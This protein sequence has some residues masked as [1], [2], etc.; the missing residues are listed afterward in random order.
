M[1]IAALLGSLQSNA[2]DAKQAQKLLDEKRYVQAREIY[3]SL[4]QKT[5]EDA[6]INLRV[7]ICYLHGTQKSKAQAYLQKAFDLSKKPD[8]HLMFDLAEAMHYNNKFDEAMVMYK[9]SDHMGTNRFTVSKRISECAFG[10][11]Y[12]ASPVMAKL[13]NMGAMV[14]TAYN[15][16]LPSVTAD[17]QAMY[18]TTRR[19]GTTGGKMADDGQFYEDI[20]ICR[21]NGGTWAGPKQLAA[22]INTKDNDACTAISSNGQT[23]FIYRGSDGGDI[24]ISELHGDVWGKPEPF[25]YNTKALETSAF[26]SFDEKKLY[27]VSDRSG[28][29]D[30]YYCLKNPN[31]S[32]GHPIRCS[33]SVNTPS[34][35][36]SPF[37][38]SDGRALYFS[39]KGHSSMGGYDIFMVG[40]NTTGSFGSPGNLG[41]PI[42]TSADDLYF[43]ISPDGKTGYFSSEKEDGFGLQDLYTVQMPP[44]AVPPGLTML[45]GNV[46][47]GRTGLPTE[48]TI[49]VTDNETKEQVT[50][51]RSN[52]KSGEFTVTLPAGKNYGIAVE[53]DGRL[54]WSKN[55]T[56][57]TT[58]T[59]EEIEEDITLPD[60]KVGA[61]VI[62]RNLFFDL[63][64]YN[65]R[66]ESYPELDRVVDLMK[67]YPS[68]RVEIGGHTDNTGDA[69]TNLTL[70]VNRAQ[71]AKDYLTGH[72][73][74]AE[75]TSV[76]GWGSTKPA[77]T[78]ATEG[79]RQLNRRTEMVIIQM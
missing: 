30:I 6:Q 11:K 79:G 12:V 78:N 58:T 44:P 5:P 3:L 47:D 61:I 4:L 31:G 56:V 70:S 38:S 26:M 60:I 67:K 15:E 62:L 64:K 50:K 10:K 18:F 52:S 65:L 33:S 17:Q 74:N 20:Y 35:E 45:K 7:G 51:I 24:F 57:T 49:T 22:P 75:R 9:K 25:V 8:D 29:K 39:S 73:I 19:P 66:P 1:L 59:Y 32:W 13:N 37:L 76:K 23:M 54:F 43:R 46:K 14:N 77:T 41:Y 34:D 63:A 68:L 2:Q 69:K 72:G 16:Y 42:N 55:V 36:E 48:A 71:S 27:F 40:V 53:K 21:N 28:N